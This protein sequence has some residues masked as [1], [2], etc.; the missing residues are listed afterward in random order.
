[1]EVK[2]ELE[3]LIDGRNDRDNERDDAKKNRGQEKSQMDS[4]VKW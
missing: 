3:C 4:D 2:E 1:M